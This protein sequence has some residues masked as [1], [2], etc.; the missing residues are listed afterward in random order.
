MNGIGNGPVVAL[1]F[2]SSFTVGGQAL[3]DLV[4]RVL[5]MLLVALLGKGVDVLVKLYLEHRRERRRA[6]ALRPG[7]KP[8]R[9][10]GDA[11]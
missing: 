5:V 9:L 6:R 7:G 3:T 10:K 11:H 1:S 8:A 4:V 2:L